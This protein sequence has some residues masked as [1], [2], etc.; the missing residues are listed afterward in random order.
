MYRQQT[1]NKSR[2]PNV[3]V[4]RRPVMDAINISWWLWAASLLI[5]VAVSGWSTVSANESEPRAHEIFLFEHDFE[6]WEFSAQPLDRI[7]IINKSNISHAIYITYPD[8]TVINL[9]VQIPGATLSWQVPYAGE[10]VL[11]CW[12]HPIIS[13]TLV[14]DEPIV[15]S[16]TKAGR[17]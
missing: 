2:K 12:I 15:L 6:R 5:I 14:V 10:F 4:Q 13:A 1:S 8:G 17:R 3:N 9:D 11:R 7:D 16:D